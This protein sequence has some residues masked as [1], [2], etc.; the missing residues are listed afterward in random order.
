MQEAG[1]E[2]PGAGAVQRLRVRYAKGET[3]KY[4]SHLDLAR[5][6]ERA[7][8]RAGLPLAY[9][10]GFNPRPRFQIAAALPVGVTG[11]AELLDVWLV[12]PLAPEAAL[13]RLRPALPPGLEAL[14]AEEVDLRAPSL[15]SQVI[16]ADYRAAVRSPEPPEA[17]RGRA[18]ALLEAPAL[19]RRRLHK[20]S[21][22]AYDLR[23]LIQEIGVE[24]GPDG[25]AVLH[26]RLQASQAGAG[27]PEEVLDALGLSPAPHGV[28]RTALHFESRAPCS[29][30]ERSAGEESA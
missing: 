18:Q 15:Q 26:L 13:S 2:G 3:L 17:I 25:A 22:Q 11:R 23:P 4:I 27:R 5:S 16:A 6:W 10:Q 19:P 30:P 21:W 9:S 12:E 8:R 1:R 29:E 20:G 28:E 14:D 7:F 24:A